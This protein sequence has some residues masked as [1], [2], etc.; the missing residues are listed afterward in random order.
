M[1][2]PQEEKRAVQGTKIASKTQKLTNDIAGPQ[3]R[4]EQF[5]SDAVGYRTLLPKNKREHVKGAYQQYEK[6]RQ[7]VNQLSQAQRLRDA[8]IQWGPKYF[9]AKET[10]ERLNFNQ[11]LLD[12]LNLSSPP[13]GSIE[14]QVHLKNKQNLEKEIGEDSER[15][16]ALHFAREI[17]RREKMLLE[18]FGIRFNSL[19]GQVVNSAYNLGLHNLALGDKTGTMSRLLTNA[20]DYVGLSE[21]QLLQASRII[22]E[23]QM[24]G[25]ALD[26][27]NDY[28]DDG[29]GNQFMDG[30]L[31]GL[32]GDAV[33]KRARM[34]DE[35]H[36]YE[37]RLNELDT[38]NPKIKDSFNLTERLD[39]KDYGMF[40]SHIDLADQN[41]VVR[42]GDENMLAQGLGYS[43]GAL[44][45][46]WLGLG[47]KMFDVKKLGSEWFKMLFM[48]PF[49][50]G[51]PRFAGD[52]MQ[53]AKEGDV[54]TLQ[55]VL[56]FMGKSYWENLT[57]NVG[58]LSTPLIA[59]ALPKIST[60]YSKFLNRLGGKLGR[61]TDYTVVATGTEMLEE[62]ISSL[63]QGEDSIFTGNFDVKRLAHLAFTTGIMGLGFATVG[64]MHKRAYIKALDA[65]LGENPELKSK[66]LGSKS[67]WDLSDEQLDNVSKQAGV[68]MGLKEQ[69]N[70][71]KDSVNDIQA[72]LS[73]Q[74]NPMLNRAEMTLQQVKSQ[75]TTEL[76]QEIGR[77]AE[78][79]LYQ[80]DG[81]SM[82]R[83]VKED[84]DVVQKDLDMYNTYMED[85]HMKDVQKFNEAKTLDMNQLN[86]ARSRVNASAGTEVL[87][88]VQESDYVNMSP[89]EYQEFR[90]N[91]IDETY[92]A[93]S[94]QSESIKF[95]SG[96][97]EREYT[98][99]KI[100]G[101]ESLPE[102]AVFVF[103][104]NAEGAH[105]KGAAKLAKEKFGARP[106]PVGSVGEHG[107]SYAIIT[108]KNWRKEK[109]STLPEIRAG[110]ANFI[111]HAK[112]NPGKKYYVT[113]IGSSLAGYSVQEIGSLFK[114][115][116]TSGE[117]IP[118]NVILPK[119]YDPRGTTPITTKTESTPSGNVTGAKGQ[120]KWKVKISKELSDFLDIIVQTGDE[121]KV[122][123]YAKKLSKDDIQQLKKSINYKPDA[124]F[125]WYRDLF[126]DTHVPMAWYYFK[127]GNLL[128]SDRTERLKQS[129]IWKDNAKFVE[130]NKEFVENYYKKMSPE[131]KDMFKKDIDKLKQEQEWFDRKIDDERYKITKQLLNEAGYV[132]GEA[133]GQTAESKSLQTVQEQLIADPSV[134]SQNK[135]LLKALEGRDTDDTQVEK[136][137]SLGE[138]IGF[139]MIDEDVL[140]NAIY[141]RIKLNPAFKLFNEEQLRDVSTVRVGRYTDEEIREA[142]QYGFDTNG[143]YLAIPAKTMSLNDIGILMLYDKTKMSF[144]EWASR[145]RESERFPAEMDPRRLSGISHEDIAHEMIDAAID[146]LPRYLYNI[147]KD[148]ENG[149][150]P[151]EFE[152][153][154]NIQNTAAFYDLVENKIKVLKDN[155]SKLSSNEKATVLNHETIHVY[156]VQGL[157]QPDEVGHNENLYNA[158]FRNAIKGLYEATKDQ[159]PS[160][161]TN[162]VPIDGMSLETVQLAE[163]VSYGMTDKKVQ[164]ILAKTP[165]GK[166]K[167]MNTWRAF[168]KAIQ[169]FLKT[170][171]GY[172]TLKQFGE[173][174]L[175][176]LM[177]D[178]SD[179]IDKYHPKLTRPDTQLEHNNNQANANLAETSGNTGK[180]DFTANHAG[181]TSSKS[182]SE[183]DRKLV[184]Q[185]LT[186]YEVHTNIPASK[187]LNEEFLDKDGNPIYGSTQQMLD[188]IKRFRSESNY[189]DEL[190]FVK[191][192]DK[193]MGLVDEASLES[194]DEVQIK[195]NLLTHLENVWL[196]LK[197][198]SNH[199]VAYFNG[200]SL[201]IH[202][203]TYPDYTF[204]NDGEV[205]NEESKSTVYKRQFYEYDIDLI[206]AKHGLNLEAIELSPQSRISEITVP[207]LVKKGYIV[208]YNKG[209]VILIKHSSLPNPVNGIKLQEMTPDELNQYNT[210]RW[211]DYYKLLFGN[212]ISEQALIKRIPF[213]SGNAPNTFISEFVMEQLSNKYGVSWGPSAPIHYDSKTGALNVRTVQFDVGPEMVAYLKEMLGED[214]KDEIVGDG[215]IYSLPIVHDTYNMINGVSIDDWAISNK[216]KTFHIEEQ[217]LKAADQTVPKDSPLAIWMKKH[218]IG[219]II[220]SSARKIKSLTE[221]TKEQT[222]TWND[223][224]DGVPPKHV[225][226]YNMRDDA[227][228]S[229]HGHVKHEIRGV[230][231]SFFTV[232][233]TSYMDKDTLKAL[234]EHLNSRFDSLYDKT[235]INVNDTDFISK[236]LRE[237]MENNEDM[238]VSATQEFI[239]NNIDKNPKIAYLLPVLDFYKQNVLQQELRDA[240]GRQEELGI[241]PILMADVGEL[242]G[243]RSQA[244]K[245]LKEHMKYSDE[246]VEKV[247]NDAFDEKGF[248]KPGYV[249][250]DRSNYETFEKH[251]T[252]GE[253]PRIL[254]SGNPPASYAD[255]RAVTVIGV[256]PN[257]RLQVERN[258]VKINSIIDRN[259]MVVNIR[260]WQ[261]ISGKD[262][263]I[264]KLG[265]IPIISGKPIEKVWDFL[266]KFDGTN[267]IKRIRSKFKESYDSYAIDSSDIIEHEI[268]L[269]KIQSAIGFPVKGF[270]KAL[271]HLVRLYGYN[272]KFKGL[273][274][275]NGY[276]ATQIGLMMKSML[277]GEVYNSRLFYSLVSEIGGEFTFKVDQATYKVKINPQNEDRN[278]GLLDALTNVTLDW[279]SDQKLLAFNYN[280][281]RTTELLYDVYK[282]KNGKFE[283]VFGEDASI[284]W[285]KNM[286]SVP[287]YAYIKMVRPVRSLLKSNEL[288]EHKT[289]QN[290][291]VLMDMLKVAHKDLFDPGTNPSKLQINKT[292]PFWNTALFHSTRHFF[293][294][295]LQSPI[296]TIGLTDQEWKKIMG[297]VSSKMITDEEKKIMHDES[298]T[299]H[300]MARFINR[301]YS[302]N[303]RNI[304]FTDLSGGKEG[305]PAKDQENSFGGLLEMSNIIHRLRAKK[306]NT[307]IF[308]KAFIRLIK[309]IINTGLLRSATFTKKVIFI[310]GAKDNNQRWEIKPIN[311]NLTFKR[312][313]VIDG[314]DT[315][316]KEYETFDD[317][318]NDTGNYSIENAIIKMS[319]TKSDGGFSTLGGFQKMFKIRNNNSLSKPLASIVKELYA[320]L[321]PS[322]VLTEM[323]TVERKAFIKSGFGLYDSDANLSQGLRFVISYKQKSQ[324]VTE[325]RVVK[326]TEWNEYTKAFNM[327]YSNPTS[328]V[329]FL[330]PYKD[331]SVDIQEIYDTFMD[332]FIDEST[333]NVEAR[334]TA[335]SKGLLTPIR[336]YSHNPN[337]TLPKDIDDIP[338]S[339]YKKDIAD[340]TDTILAQEGTKP[341]QIVDF[342]NQNNTKKIG[343]SQIKDE[344]K[345]FYAQFLAESFFNFKIS[346]EKT[347]KYK[348]QYNVMKTALKMFAKAQRDPEALR[349]TKSYSLGKFLPAQWYLKRM[350][351]KRILMQPGE[352]VIYM[353]NGEP[354][355]ISAFEVGRSFNELVRPDEPYMTAGSMIAQE[356]MRRLNYGFNDNIHIMEKI[357]ESV[358]NVLHEKNKYIQGSQ[359][360]ELGTE[361]DSTPV[362]YVLGKQFQATI[363]DI[364]ETGLNDVI[365]NRETGNLIYKLKK[366]EI[367]DPLPLGA[368]HK[369]EVPKWNIKVL[370]ELATEIA[371]KKYKPL[372]DTSVHAENIRKSILIR[373]HMSA[374]MQRYIYDYYTNVLIDVQIENLTYLSR[375]AGRMS[376]DVAYAVKSMIDG[377]HGFVEKLE[378]MKRQIELKS[379]NLSRVGKKYMPR[380]FADPEMYERGLYEAEKKINDA[381]PKGHK[382]K[383]TEKQLKAKVKSII[384][385]KNKQADRFGYPKELLNTNFFE[386][387]RDDIGY[388]RKDPMVAG[389]YLSMLMLTFRHDFMSAYDYMYEEYTQYDSEEM[390]QEIRHQAAI[391]RTQN[392]YFVPTDFASL[393]KNK[394]V[395]FIWKGFVKP[396]I[397][398]PP[399]TVITG[400]V[401]SINHKTGEVTIKLTKPLYHPVLK[402]NVEEI[403]VTDN[404]MRN[405]RETQPLTHARK[406]DYFI[407]QLTGSDVDLNAKSQ[408]LGKW[409][410]SMRNYSMLTMKVNYAPR[411]RM[412]SRMNRYAMFGSISTY[413]KEIKDLRV[414]YN[415]YLQTGNESVLTESDITTFNMLK[416]EST[417]VFGEV[418]ELMG[419]FGADV[420]E[421][422]SLSAEQL[423]LINKLNLQWGNIKKELEPLYDEIVG[424]P[425]TIGQPKRWTDNQWKFV[426][427]IFGAE[428]DAFQ[429]FI[430]KGYHLYNPA[431]IVADKMWDSMSA[432]L[433]ASVAEKE[434]R[435]ETIFRA[436]AYYQS[437]FD[438]ATMSDD[439]KKIFRSLM[440]DIAMALYKQAVINI[441]FLYQPG[442]DLSHWDSTV[443]GR[444]WLQFSH[445]GNMT[446]NVY[447]DKLVGMSQQFKQ[448]G[449]M[450][451]V[452]G[453]KKMSYIGR[454]R[455]IKTGQI[456]ENMF[457]DANQ[458]RAFNR[459]TWM[460]IIVGG[461]KEF[462]S[463]L[464][465]FHL[466]AV[467]MTAIWDIVDMATRLIISDSIGV[468]PTIALWH[469]I[470]WIIQGM[471]DTGPDDRPVNEKDKERLNHDT[472]EHWFTMPII[473]K[474]VTTH[475]VKRAFATVFGESKEEFVRHETWRL[476]TLA[477]FEGWSRE[478]RE[479]ITPEYIGAVWE[480]AQRQKEKSSIPF[481]GVAATQL[482]E[483]LM[484]SAL[485]YMESLGH[486]EMITNVAG[487]QVPVF[488]VI[489]P[490]V[491][492]FRPDVGFKM[493]KA[494]TLEYEIKREYEMLAQEERRVNDAIKEFEYNDNY[495]EKRWGPGSERTR[496]QKLDDKKEW[497]D[498]LQRTNWKSP[499]YVMDSI[500][501][502]Y[503][504]RMDNQKDSAEREII[505]ID[506]IVSGKIDSIIASVMFD[507]LLANGA[508]ERF[509]WKY[510]NEIL[511]E[512]KNAYARQMII[513]LGDDLLVPDVQKDV[514][515]KI[516]NDM[517]EY[518]ESK[519]DMNP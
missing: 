384:E 245:W 186:N 209:T 256:I 205:I 329:A 418:N 369:F 230:S 40:Y 339:A 287:T 46:F 378:H 431:A 241:Y 107:K 16:N 451:V 358:I 347:S 133:S 304:E 11:S 327:M 69:W 408:V 114:A 278:I 34:R 35:L 3:T 349:Y 362:P 130:E 78:D 222:S 326:R 490:L 448:F 420:S 450:E 321:I 63:L 453:P 443:W 7:E 513:D 284:P 406:L 280:N 160:Y 65:K 23:I 76:E 220:F 342:W 461:I 92:Q 483:F 346:F 354:H 55:D 173:S 391:V 100:N 199:K 454:I 388:Y 190:A 42:G 44:P 519:A 500:T 203:G 474:D 252:P 181:L 33:G 497:L 123:P 136:V 504:F 77:L 334:K 325:D 24:I 477:D 516:M 340:L 225:Y 48:S 505:N 274:L 5:V 99:E 179:Y 502:R 367:V 381:L 457:H 373:Q 271:A 429:E 386:R 289:L 424:T 294:R 18:K 163:F 128:I 224:I 64:T 438:D 137:E 511:M 375:H 296:G 238:F 216:Y 145:N 316:T 9:D 459:M 170:I 25:S 260:D 423:T 268:N 58:E 81:E 363:Y 462:L 400:E 29:W 446:T 249:M 250:I 496:W 247:L 73:Q 228:V 101:P 338:L 164:E 236:K 219:K 364:A 365:I 208:Q 1:D 192:K 371:M 174:A 39:P 445:Y 82:M 269:D 351:A 476:N 27:T 139:Q 71:I 171:T 98:P 359:K 72:Q 360:A 301:L 212:D 458:L 392:A 214:Y 475:D 380:V 140:S 393:K 217:L 460:S 343:Q 54:N 210:D 4:E 376:P 162:P 414:R 405:L 74:D 472:I 377:P 113:K 456:L 182:T 80:F 379:A 399:G 355:Y 286:I 93:A 415:E 231:P 193:M 312:V 344:H 198:L 251:M 314:K 153:R 473:N 387:E 372:P 512:D 484:A 51:G 122:D 149:I 471:W 66:L 439:E 510:K 281:D 17:E 169:D 318:F 335:Q 232:M 436:V 89:V 135:E 437:S 469:T 227:F 336:F 374:L 195:T 467:G 433:N 507:S 421:M 129:K 261:A 299:P 499:R 317:M 50:T 404:Q 184:D 390:Q 313:T 21:D 10:V 115:I 218:N 356:I 32:L 276:Q 126:D 503:G 389:D 148:V 147:Q 8:L 337:V 401:K 324:S 19:E 109:S 479:K 14:Q 361:D 88:L 117:V 434:N 353:F 308:E 368:N 53:A 298:S 87:T 478:D 255:I 422:K 180:D 485:G 292:N 183:S 85:I 146:E 498:F 158:D 70:H 68:V 30:A 206:N 495:V 159:L 452:L 297:K 52:L 442:L 176:N 56:M 402:S 131:D 62:E 449:V 383:L 410:V 426:Q 127:T 282:L 315:E 345:L 444:F 83:D 233:L 91:L 229:S 200:K 223:V 385:A 242:S 26:A 254:L 96:S 178:V 104:S 412:G 124:E 302:I 466:T 487:T 166:A 144:E 155:W 307:E 215:A 428:G 15:Y 188:D 142:E 156:T 112:K 28:L 267:K 197:G 266:S 189:N 435:I 119:E 397:S 90:N 396:G 202:S 244:R 411:N 493:S 413:K 141:E 168:L 187:F 275:S 121:T 348:K 152:V 270:D 235:L 366:Y 103:G 291:A 67:L 506:P 111:R 283:Q 125:D 273:K 106:G 407:Y 491:Q 288:P 246:Q 60:A 31:K 120:T 253:L 382:D 419:R 468:A 488:Q 13:E 277:I 508:P 481:M 320:E 196:N 357:G 204:D 79:T 395:E 201:S 2:K 517:E 37:S 333:F 425:E 22:T 194:K 185:T 290:Y 331:K 394:T 427:K 175:N 248:I 494:K 36:V 102:N 403:D 464:G 61:F 47:T 172:N 75:L 350:S 237:F 486:M 95:Y 49:K 482:Y 409:V 259:G 480:Q 322:Y 455:D 211:L 167:Q 86:S 265:G 306:I 398:N 257:R 323:T 191:W 370:T 492:A 41:A 105:G 305:A 221:H 12:N 132:D 213:H 272:S 303:R 515:K 440:G 38:K 293:R 332:T 509:A 264:D 300:L 447:F 243:Y 489:M 45:M 514:Q 6:T 518:I 84:L 430:F 108:K 328:Y 110:I 258:G 441:D 263:D 311:G 279:S 118:D 134:N 285:G 239:E 416:E 97:Q 463:V 341:H 151:Q 57:E 470:G 465:R 501:S 143:Y 43:I 177:V 262:F 20:A 138:N 234:T 150:V 432:Y 161:I 417:A 226:T 154:F 240:L 330:D 319:M 207:E 59:R 116:H 310:D 352:R 309:N 94:K 157:I 295:Y 165:Y